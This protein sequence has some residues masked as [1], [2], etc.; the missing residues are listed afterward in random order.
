[1]GGFE[2]AKSYYMNVN[3][4]KLRHLAV[5]C[6]L[7]SVPVLVLATGCMVFVKF[8]EAGTE[9]LCIPILV[10]FFI[11]A[12]GLWYVNYKHQVIFKQ[13]YVLA[14]EHE[15]PLHAHVENV[16]RSARDSRAV[17]V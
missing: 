15:F 14:K 6:F 4:G 13:Q 11:T 8:S 7:F 10:L 2:I 3:I 12:M 17:D 5:K 9:K 16:S 1:M